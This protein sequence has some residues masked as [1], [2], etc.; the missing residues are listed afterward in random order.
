MRFVFNY[1]LDRKIWDLRNNGMN[2]RSQPINHPAVGKC[3]RNNR[4]GEVYKIRYA[5]KMFHNGWWVE[6]FAFDERNSSRS[7]PWQNISCRDKDICELIE[8]NNYAYSIGN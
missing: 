4:D 3:I 2:L 5:K 7:I 1:D 6:L 8:E